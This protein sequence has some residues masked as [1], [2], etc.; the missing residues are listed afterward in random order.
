[1]S[2][3]YEIVFFRDAAG[4]EPFTDWLS[5]L[6][7]SVTR[8]RILKR[9]FR[10]EQGNFGDH[11]S[12][13]DGVWELRFTFGAGYRVYYA[14]DG[15]RIIILLMGGDKGSQKRDI[16]RAKLYWQEYNQNE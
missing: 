13:K 4:K 6:R 11:Q 2:K 9:L 12:L 10:V 7:D 1:M 14:L 5:R 3:R 16:A 15:D 8:R